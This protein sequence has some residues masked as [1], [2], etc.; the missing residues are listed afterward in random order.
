LAA[1]AAQVAASGAKGEQGKA[2]IDA[3]KTAS[4]ERINAKKLEIEEKVGARIASAKAAARA[5]AQKRL[6]KAEQK[7]AEAI[8]E[9]VDSRFPYIQ[10]G[11]EQWIDPIIAVRARCRLTDWAYLGAYGDIGGFGV[12]SDLT[13]QASAQLGFQISRS[14]A[15]ELGYRYL[16]IDYQNGDFIFEASA[17][18]PMIGAR[19]TF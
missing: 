13:W 7:L 16:C 17:S 9:E 6:T 2:A 4:I 5:K 18:G 12:G 11:S 19:F 8:A 3:A 1:H 15:L 14:F 10:E